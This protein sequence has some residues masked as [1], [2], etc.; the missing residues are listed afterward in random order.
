[1]ST[2]KNNTVRGL[3]KHAKT[4][5]YRRSSTVSKKWTAKATDKLIKDV[6]KEYKLTRTTTTA[7]RAVAKNSGVAGRGALIKVLVSAKYD[8]KSK[9]KS[10]FKTIAK[11]QTKGVK[12]KSAIEMQRVIKTG[13]KEAKSARNTISNIYSE[14]LAKNI[15]RATKK[16]KGQPLSDEQIRALKNKAFVQT[17][18]KIHELTHKRGKYDPSL[19][20]LYD[21]LFDLSPKGETSDADYNSEDPVI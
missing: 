2:K 11:S 6:S 21:A 13:L 10:L 14:K 15:A 16:N 12:Q 4:V 7:L 1:M 8:V 3:L 9:N 5:E 20:S 17:R 19:R 18:K